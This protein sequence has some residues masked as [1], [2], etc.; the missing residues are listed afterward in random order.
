MSDSERSHATIVTLRYKEVYDGKF[1]ARVL[2]RDDGILG[3]VFRVK[4]PFNY[5]VFEMIREAK[6]GYKQIR[7]FVNGKASV[8]FKLDDGGY[9]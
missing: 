5:Y 6:G 2:T 1:S 7:K 3:M 4:D 8:I 9:L